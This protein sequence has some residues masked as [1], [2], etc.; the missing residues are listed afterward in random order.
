MR[1]GFKF[2]DKHS[3]DF[4]VTVK[5]KSRPIR[6]EAKVYTLD[7]PCRDGV[8][9]FSEAN[10]AGREYFYDRTFVITVNVCADNLYTLQD[11]LSLLSAWLIGSG[12]LIF[13]DMPNTVW[14]GKISD[15]IIYMPNHGGK[16]SVMEISLR[17][18]PFGKCIFGTDGPVLDTYIRLDNTI[19]LALNETMHYEISGGANIAV[20]NFGERP[21]RPCIHIQGGKNI[22]L[23]LNSK[24]LSFDSGGDCAVDFDKQSVIV[25]GESVGVKGEFF[26][27]QAGDN[28]LYIENSNSATVKIDVSYTPEFNYGVNLEVIDWGVDNA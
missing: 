17:V 16:N 21:I 7:I 20:W 6:P 11:K 22:I 1:N 25:K 15:E 18:R 23:T 13:D 26:E 10:Q 9:D 14:Y 28:L 12:E 24:T 5:T 3:S 27:F 4:G 19:P 2:K 8:Y